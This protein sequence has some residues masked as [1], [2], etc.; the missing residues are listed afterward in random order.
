MGRLLTIVSHDFQQGVHIF[1]LSVV[2]SEYLCP[3]R[4]LIGEH[5]PSLG[6]HG[7]IATQS[8]DFLIEWYIVGRP[9]TW[10]KISYKY[11][12]LVSAMGQNI[13]TKRNLFLVSWGEAEWNGTLKQFRFHQMII[14][15]YIV[16]MRSINIWSHDLRS[17]S[18]KTNP[19]SKFGIDMPSSSGD[20]APTTILLL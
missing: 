19:H 6:L 20:I 5:I 7:W 11:W 15:C 9:I 13:I 12:L 8:V 14:F 3:W 4:Q 17:W 18:C 16:W 1:D 10:I 2:S